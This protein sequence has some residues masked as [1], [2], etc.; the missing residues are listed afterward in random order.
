MKIEIPGFLSTMTGRVR[1]V[2]SLVIR[3]YPS[4]FEDVQIL[5]GREMERGDTPGTFE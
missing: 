3:I 5:S 2:S 1:T 4:K